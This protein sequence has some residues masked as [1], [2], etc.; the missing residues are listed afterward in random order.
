MEAR[1]IFVGKLV[2]IFLGEIFLCEP[3]LEI[4][5][6]VQHPLSSF[7]Q[8]LRFVMVKKLLEVRRGLSTWLVE[9]VLSSIEPGC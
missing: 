1:C 3:T 4:V 2:R 7:L 8:V 5:L 6:V 9:Y